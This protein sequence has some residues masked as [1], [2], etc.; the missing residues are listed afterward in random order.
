MIPDN[1]RFRLIDL[2]REDDIYDPRLVAS[3]FSTSG[4]TR[5]ANTTAYS[6]KDVMTDGVKKA[7][8]FP[9]FSP[10][11]GAAIDILNAIMISSN[12]AASPGA[13]ELLLFDSP[14]DLAADNSAYSPSNSDILELLGVVC[15]DSY[16]VNAISSVYHLA[17]FGHLY[18]RLAPGSTSLY[19]VL[20][21]TAAYTP[22]STEN[23]HIKLWGEMVR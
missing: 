18:V 14:Q 3:V 6:A 17:S 13:F 2:W 22:I 1:D 9:N 21:S 23:F 8:E 7:M 5:P 19:G 15:F 11:P 4:F 20:V 10:V 12:P 16:N